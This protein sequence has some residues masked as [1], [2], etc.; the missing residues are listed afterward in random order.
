[1]AKSGKLHLQG[2]Q[3]ITEQTQMFI[4]RVYMH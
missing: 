1:M 2:S 3:E 4:N